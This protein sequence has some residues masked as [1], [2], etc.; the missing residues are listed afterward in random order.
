MKKLNTIL[1]FAS[2]AITSFLLVF[3][4]FAWYVTNTTATVEGVVG[5][6]AIG[7]NLYLSTT[8]SGEDS[9]LYSESSFENGGWGTTVSLDASNILLPASTNDATN[10]YYTN[11]INTDGSAIVNAGSYN[12]NLVNTSASYYYVSKTIYLTTSETSNLNCCLRSISIEQG[13][14]TTSNIFEAVRVSFSSGV[15]T[16]IFKATNDT[17]LPAVSTTGVAVADPGL[18]QGGQANTAFSFQIPGATLSGDDTTYHVIA[19]TVKIWVEGQHPD[20]IAT[21]AGTG[22]KIR[23]GFQSY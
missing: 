3:L 9:F 10:F 11:D 1:S 12:F 15:V 13:T 14:D 7:K 17:V 18:L 4:I 23:M 2:L 21:Y 8:Y 16:K 19:V 5:A 20:A 22:F 6:T